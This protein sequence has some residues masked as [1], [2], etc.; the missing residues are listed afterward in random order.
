MSEDTCLLSATML[1]WQLLLPLLLLPAALSTQEAFFEGDILLK[2]IPLSQTTPSMVLQ[3]PSLHWPHG[4]V[5]YAFDA[6]SKFSDAEKVI[7]REAMN[8][9]EE[10]TNSCTEFSE[11]ERNRGGDILIITSHGWKNQAGTG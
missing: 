3:N 6:L 2:S 9:I 7:V 5:P 1:E 4:V 8:S 10:K 11:V